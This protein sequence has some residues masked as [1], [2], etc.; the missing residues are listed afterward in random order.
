M[1]D[2]VP[3]RYRSGAAVAVC[4]GGIAVLADVAPDDP[5]VGRLADEL[6]SATSTDE[7]VELLISQ[8]LRAISSFGVLQPVHDGT[9][10]VVRGACAAEVAGSGT[11]HGQGLWADRFVPSTDVRLTFGSPSSGPTLRIGS[12]IVLACEVGPALAGASFQPEPRRVSEPAFPSSGPGD[13]PARADVATSDGAVAPTVHVTMPGTGGQAE[14]ADGS[15][16]RMDFGELAHAREEARQATAA[17]PAAPAP[18]DV[19]PPRRA[20][21]QH[22]VAAPPSGVPQETGS[23]AFI[24][25]VPSWMSDGVPPGATPAAGTASP[26]P[27]LPTTG[28]PAAATT[29]PGPFPASPHHQ[30][31][32]EAA[33]RTVSRAALRM[34]GGPDGPVVRA[35]Q[36]A[37]GHLSPAHA[38]IC[39]VCRGPVPAQPGFEVVRP[40]L[41]RL[42][43]AN[44]EVVVLDRSL[45]MGRNPMVPVG[46]RGEQP[47]LL[48]L[49]DPGKDL[50]SQ[51]A[52]VRLD[53]W[54]VVVNDLG[55]T[56]GTRVMLPGRE[57]IQLRPGDP[58]TI[59]PG[60]EVVLA[61]VVQCVFE[62][63]E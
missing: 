42:R 58:I 57:P 11:V 5:I 29:G 45:V 4:G 3:F 35:A 27:A 6:P 8:G 38:A 20:V 28:V 21:S 63:T 14:P 19:E 13:W 43:F 16:L 32:D 18:W 23:P 46:Y 44:G 7:V 15:T 22:P 62:V 41:G 1:S 26:A 50:S 36:C 51:H 37:Y 52:E 40:P 39:R 30:P 61:G 54:H 2:P 25:A 34:P 48:R 49:N 31:K 60:T 12:G 33:Q 9:R 24:G 17:G 53:Y 56:N 10:V 47:N 59:E 55:S